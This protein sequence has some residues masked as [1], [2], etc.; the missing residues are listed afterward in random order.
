[1]K[2]EPEQEPL[3]RT[4]WSRPDENSVYLTA[5]K[6]I[7]NL[8]DKILASALKKLAVADANSGGIDGHAVIEW[9]ETHISHVEWVIHH[10]QHDLD[11]QRSIQELLP[12]TMKRQCEECETWFI[13][14]RA[15]QKFHS[16]VCRQSAYR[17][18]RRYV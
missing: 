18:R 5:S 13:P 4:I 2:P 14:N 1:L 12:E 11:I 3:R 7:E 8:D 17:K 6:H 9:L 16:N 15:D 10:I